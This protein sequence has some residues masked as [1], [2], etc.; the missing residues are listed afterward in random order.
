VS[1]DHPEEIKEGMVFALETFWP[2]SDGWSAA[3][4]EEQL[5]V[6][7]DGCEI[8]TRFPAED[9][10]IAGK[11][12]FTVGGSLAL[13]RDPQSNRNTVLNADTQEATPRMQD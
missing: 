1:L 10:V 6:T 5:V 4:I 9:L 2:A 8:I 3:R 12:Y 11:P 7:H 13:E